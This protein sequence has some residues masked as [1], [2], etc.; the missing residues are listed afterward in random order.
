MAEDTLVLAGGVTVSRKADKSIRYPEQM[1]DP[2]IALYFD[3]IEEH[4]LNIQ[5]QI[6]DNYI[7]NNTSIQDHIAHAPITIS[8][9][10]LIGEV[11]YKP[12]MTALNKIIGKI[13]TPLAQKYGIFISDKLSPIPALLPSVSNVTQL[14]RNAVQYVEASYRRYEKIIKSFGEGRYRQTRLEEVFD[15]LKTLRDFN[16]LLIVETPY[17]VFDNM[18]IQSITLRQGNI[19]YTSDIEITLKQINYASTYNTEPNK[20]VMA[21]YNAIQRANEANHGKAQ[22]QRVD[23]TFIGELAVKYLGANPSGGIRRP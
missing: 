20:K 11:V 6:T 23:S 16:D 15:K 19:N 13:D 7:E 22:G 12:P 10:G 2:R 17:Q 8:M 18:V 9:R 5:N 21:M 14:A 1:P 3:T 4:T